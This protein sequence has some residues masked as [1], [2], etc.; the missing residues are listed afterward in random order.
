MDYLIRESTHPQQYTEMLEDGKLPLDVMREK[1]ESKDLTWEKLG[2]FAKY[3]KG[4]T[5]ATAE[6]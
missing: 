4:L 2:E 6:A 1:F 3:I 5:D